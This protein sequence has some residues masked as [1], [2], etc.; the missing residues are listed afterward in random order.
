MIKITF[1]DGSVR[2]YAKG[3]TS[4]QIAESISSRLAQEVLAA[5]VNGEIW[6]LT[7]PIEQDVT[8]ELLK[9][10][11][12]DAKHAY[13]HSSAHLMAEAVQILYPHAKFG[14]GPA[15]ENGFYYDI[16]F[17]DTP[18]K[19]SD[20]P[21]I[22]AKMMELIANKEEIK[23][24]SITKTDALQLFNGRHENYK[25]ELI[26]DLEDG[27]ITTYTQGVFTDLCRGPHLP[28]T[29]YIKA[30]K[31]LSAA[32]AYWRGD[33]TRKQLTRL[34][35]ITFPKKK[36]LDDYLLMLEEAKKR[37]HRKIGKELELF[38]FSEN[39]GKGLPL[40]LPRGTQLRLKLED[41]LKK[42]Q[43]K[44][45]YEQVMTP[46]IG[47]KILY[48]TSG[49]YEKYGKDSFQPIH[50]PEEGEEFLLKP[51]NCPHHCE[52][53][54]VVPRSYKDLPLR[55]AEFGTVYRYEQS[56]ELHGLT[57]V[58]GFTQDDAHIFCTPEQLKT[59]FL[60]VMDIVFIIF[61]ALDFENFEAQISLR[62]PENK[63]KY[64]GSDEN[65]EKAERAIIEA[66]EEKGLPAK[67]EL[68]EAAFYGPKLDF[69]VKDAL[70]R[71]WQLGTIQVDYNLPERFELEY[72]GSDNQKHRPVMIH[73]APFGSM[74]RFIAVL[75]EHTAGKF[76]L[77]LAPDQVV[78]LP[79]SEKF[80][81]YAYRV[82]GYLRQKGISSQVDDRNEK[83]GRKIRDN[84]L[85]RIPY[86]L[87]VGEKEAETEEVSVR[88][89]GEGDTG[90]MKFINFAARLN[91]EMEKMMN[92]W[93]L[94]S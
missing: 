53:Y 83:I 61:K 27:T 38:A 31:I 25:V 32:G 73:R 3:T 23:R 46:H 24:Q 36:M 29:S 82:S 62:D 11:D 21:K 39:V 44:F 94:E 26:N 93:E 7:R 69:M 47:S 64:I 70:G 18:V 79:I 52:I 85:K 2:E 86:L 9:W 75:I 72:T 65:W 66:C 19:D 84:E 71:R 43:K 16:D 50:T 48:V 1:P 89:Q 77:W 34:Y 42:I 17:G 4:L 10:E 63:Q 78:V 76:P 51:M 87:I 88:K 80:N 54:K 13:W 57:R 68:G 55:L 41:F 6:D 14:I 67:V 5:K 49:H 37:D 22:E 12:D 58:R 8:I 60:K 81:D 40:W 59:E 91:E 20:F 56:G 35:G 28:N 90:S 33:E 15:I 30:V 74:E 45:D 92:A